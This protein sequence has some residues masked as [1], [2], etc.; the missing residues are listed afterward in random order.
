MKCNGPVECGG[1]EM[2]AQF[3]TEIDHEKADND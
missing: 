1:D 2:W 3:K